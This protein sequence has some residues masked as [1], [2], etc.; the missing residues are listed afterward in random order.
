VSLAGRAR[1]AGRQVWLAGLGVLDLASGL[2]R[3][4]AQ[5]WRTVERLAARGEPV[6]VRQR[7]R[8][9]R[10]G[11]RASRTA[12][13]ARTLLRDTAAYEGRRLLKRFDLAT[14]EDMHQLAVRLEALD[15]KLDNY[16]ARQGLTGR[17]LLAGPV[18]PGGL[19]P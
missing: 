7:A 5:G 1:A 9:D 10:L 13:S 15:R 18:F 16:A 17:P 8:I 4:A 11:E 3:W 2:P 12:A 19:K 14:D 6:A